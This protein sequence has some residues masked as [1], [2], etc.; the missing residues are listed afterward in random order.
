MQFLSILMYIY[1][2]LA[3]LTLFY[4]EVHQVAQ[5]YYSPIRV[6]SIDL[7]FQEDWFIWYYYD[8]CYVFFTKMGDFEILYLWDELY[9]LDIIIIEIN[10]ADS[11][12]SLFKLLI[13]GLCQFIEWIYFIMD[14][15]IFHEKN[16]NLSIC[17]L[18]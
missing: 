9:W 11:I 5:F 8:L 15:L 3:Q 2:N 13:L 7:N 14:K 10:F 4:F 12:K 16:L 17:Q 1:L 18:L 6:Q